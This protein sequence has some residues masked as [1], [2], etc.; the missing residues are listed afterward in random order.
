MKN[1]LAWAIL[2]ETFQDG[3]Y[4]ANWSNNTIYT[5]NEWHWQ[6]DNHELS[7]SI[8]L[9]DNQYWKLYHSRYVQDGETTYSYGFGGQACRMVEIEYITTAKSPHSNMLKI[10]GDKE[11]IRTYEY[12]TKIHKIINAGEQNDKYGVPYSEGK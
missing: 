1:T 4:Y 7:F 11:W 8:Y 9:H 6:Y 5:S 12:N 3:S 10:A 2:G